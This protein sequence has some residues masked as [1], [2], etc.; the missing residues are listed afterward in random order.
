MNPDD[1]CTPSVSIMISVRSS[2]RAARLLASNA[3]SLPFLT[4]TPDEPE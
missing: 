2:T 4:P 3:V 1:E